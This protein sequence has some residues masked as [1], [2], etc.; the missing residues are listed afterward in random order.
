MRHL[1]LFSGIG[2]FAIACKALGI[3][4]RHF[5]EIDPFCRQVLKQHFPRVPIHGDIK[6]FSTTTDVF[7]LVTAG[8]P[9]QDLSLANANGRGLEGERSGLVYEAL[10]IISEAQ[11]RFVLLENVPGF[12]LGGLSEVLRHLALMRF[13]AEWQTISA[14]SVGAPHQRKR[15]F[16]I[17]YPQGI[18]SPGNYQDQEGANLTPI[19][20]NSFWRRHEAPE[21]SIPRMDDGIPSGLATNLCKSLGNSVVPQVALIPLNKIVKLNQQFY[22][23]NQ[24]VLDCDGLDPAAIVSSDLGRS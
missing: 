23:G 5:V 16:I 18:G 3:T 20:R 17:A 8:F 19:S 11:P 7:D 6:T 24:S 1:D 2:G 14:S 21:P 9:C 10:R 22:T 13:D 15:V 12:T 4:T